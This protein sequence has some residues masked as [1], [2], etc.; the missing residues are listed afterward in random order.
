MKF[1]EYQTMNLNL[2]LKEMKKL[3]R[4]IKSWSSKKNSAKKTR[5]YVMSSQIWWRYSALMYAEHQY[6]TLDLN[7]PDFT[8]LCQELFCQRNCK[9]HK[10]TNHFSSLGLILFVLLVATNIGIQCN[11]KM[12][13]DSADKHQIWNALLRGPMSQIR[14][15]FFSSK[16]NQY[17]ENQQ[18][19]WRV[20]WKLSSDLA[21]SM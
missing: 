16:N 14:L 15:L 19:T 21:F 20:Y 2:Q 1:L 4:Y 5:Q 9:R 10:E 7:G 17:R 11:T 18:S 3:K 12:K 8:L 13:G 6:V